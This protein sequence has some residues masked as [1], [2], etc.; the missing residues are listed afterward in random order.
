MVLLDLLALLVLQ[1]IVVLLDLMVPEAFKVCLVLRG[2]QV[3]LEKMAKQE[4]LV[5]QE[6]QESKES[7][8]LG[9]FL[10]NVEQLVVLAHLD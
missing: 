3:N 8:D 9:D 4:F 1:V 2:K 10:E 5:N 6:E 7:R